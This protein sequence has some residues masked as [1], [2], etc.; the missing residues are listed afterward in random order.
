MINEKLGLDAGNM[1]VQ[2][3]HRLGALKRRRYRGANS[4]PN[5]R[6]IIICFRDYNDVEAIL[7]NAFKLRNT[8]LGINK[9]F[10]KEIV[11]ARSELWPRYKQEKQKNPNGRVFIG[12]PAK[13]VVNGKVICD[14]F[15]DWREVLKGSR[16]NSDTSD[17][18]NKSTEN[19]EGAVG[20]QPP[21]STRPDYRDTH[22]DDRSMDRSDTDEDRRDSVAAMESEGDVLDRGTGERDPEPVS[23]I[24]D[25]DVTADATGER[26]ASA[27]DDAMNLLSGLADKNKTAD[28]QSHG[29][30]H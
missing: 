9:D 16:I 27:Y 6:P 26:A 28:S 23:P 15:P 24:I 13:L 17:S 3:A 25:R 8:N 22:H 1:F 7:A 21:V 14:K 29:D 10:P 11:N 2:R 18:T 19:K 5:P 4:R 20:G 30:R 12:I